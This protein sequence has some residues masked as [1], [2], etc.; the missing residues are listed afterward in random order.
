MVTLITLHLTPEG[1]RTRVH[2]EYARTALDPAIN[3]HVQQLS[4]VDANAGPEW[5]EQVNECLKKFKK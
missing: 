1:D 4:D 2:V 5:E 3:A